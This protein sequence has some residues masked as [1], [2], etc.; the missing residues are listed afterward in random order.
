[1]EGSFRAPIVIRLGMFD[2]SGAEGL[3]SHLCSRSFLAARRR[4]LKALKASFSFLD[5]SL[6]SFS[7][8]ATWRLC[9][10]RV[11][12]ISLRRDCKSFFSYF[13]PAGARFPLRVGQALREKK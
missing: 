3:G 11:F 2:S 8:A 12:A 7:V 5:K 1:M 6:S 13:A 9:F 4:S 10:S